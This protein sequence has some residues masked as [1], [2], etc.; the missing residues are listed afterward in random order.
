MA[1]AADLAEG[2]VLALAPLAEA[3]IFPNLSSTVPANPTTPCIFIQDGPIE[4]D[5][6][7]RR[8]FDL[9][10]FQVMAFVARSSDIAQQQKLRVIRASSGEFSV[11]TLLEVDTKL[12]GAAE[13][14]QVKMLS[15]I[16][17][18]KIEGTGGSRQALGCE[19]TVKVMASGDSTP[20]VLS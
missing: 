20:P 9:W 8:G 4:Y 2:L 5:K 16:H 13:H 19:W 7:F 1:S 6:T 11:K 15:G 14:L 3:E 18:Y 12:G 17:E 10:Q